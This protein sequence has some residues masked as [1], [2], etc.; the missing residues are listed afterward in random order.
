MKL[1]VNPRDALIGEVIAGSKTGFP[2]DKSLSHRAAL[3]AALA[4]GESVIHNLLVS[5]VTRAMLNSLSALGVVW[6]LNDRSLTVQGIG[7]EGFLPQTGVLDCGNSATTM[8]LLAGAIALTGIPIVLDGS[9]GLRHRPMGRIIDPLQ[10]MGVP[11]TASDGGRAPIF[12]EQRAGTTALK[13]LEHWLPVASAQV[14]SCIILASLAADGETRIIEPGPSRDHTERML[15]SMGVDIRSSQLS[16]KQFYETII[17]PSNATNL[18]PLQITLPGDISSAAFLIVAALIVPD[19]NIVLR[20]VG[21]N[22]TRTGLLDALMQMGADI[23]ITGRRLSAGES[24]GDLEVRYTPLKAINLSGELVVR[25]IDEFP[26]FAIAASY[27]DGITTVSEAEELRKK[28]SDR[29]SVLCNNLLG[30]G[31]DIKEKADGFQICGG[32]GIMGGDASAYGDH[33]LAM[34]MA[35]AGM[36]SKKS[37]VIEGAEIINESFPQFIDAFQVLGADI[38]LEE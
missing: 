9:E 1:R 25:M 10:A 14:K 29:I 15:S 30:L 32:D 21:L 36:A 34:S 19:S 4:E 12:I 3:F 35:V 26:I 31:V 8:R 27:A 23:R 28:E 6:Q 5:G 33:R 22:P 7:A 18:S 11:I 37:V 17:N 16:E 20:G 2:G 13:G 24:V 38:K